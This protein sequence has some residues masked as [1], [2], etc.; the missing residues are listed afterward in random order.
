MDTSWDSYDQWKLWRITDL[1][2]NQW[3]IEAWDGD[4]ALDEVFLAGGWVADS[5]QDFTIEEVEE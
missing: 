3:E 5:D 1:A 2:G 4:S